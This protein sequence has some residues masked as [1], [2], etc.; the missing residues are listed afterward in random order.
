MSSSSGLVLIVDDTMENIQ[1]LGSLLRDA[2][3]SI[4]VATNG[5]Q[6]LTTLERVIPDLVLLDIMM[7]VMDGFEVCRRMK[8]HPDWRD[9]PVIFLT[10]KVE[11][12]SVVEGFELGAVDYV[13]K[14]FQAAELLKRVDTHLT[15]SRLR[16]ELASRVDELSDALDQ[17]EK[18]HR[19][20]DAFLRHELNNVINPIAGYTSMLES[21]VGSVLDE[22]PRSWLKAISKG[23]DS[24]QRM[25]GDLKD[26]NEVERGARTFSLMPVPLYGILEDVIR[27]V[28]AASQGQVPVKLSPETLD[29]RVGADLSFLPGVFKNLIKNAVEHVAPGPDSGA[30]TSGPDGRGVLVQCNASESSVTIDIING[31]DPV[32][33]ERLTT[34]FEKFNSTKAGEGGTGLGTTYA[35]I[36]TEAH[37]GS[38]SVSSSA[39]DGTRVR[40]E[41]PRVVS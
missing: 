8:Q 34:F 41:L 27:D 4:N 26:L 23:T 32:P 19:E 40:V 15:L 30:M 36:V 1:V 18:L 33:Q 14:P 7:P 37:G 10:A 16:R 13:T 11:T 31:G 35:R 2:G 9:I 22:K 21:S 39:E 25:L 28:R 6:A 17:I 20:Q 12:E 29:A 5:T 24:M 38:I 3:Y